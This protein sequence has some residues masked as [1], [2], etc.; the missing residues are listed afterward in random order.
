[1]KLKHNYVKDMLMTEKVLKHIV[2]G[3]G[4]YWFQA[5]QIAN[6]KKIQNDM[7]CFFFQEKK[8]MNIGKTHSITTADSKLR[9]WSRK[10]AMF[11]SL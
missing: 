1:M 10:W 2:N 9:K 6:E 3:K 4:F 8:F 7:H 11:Q 5:L